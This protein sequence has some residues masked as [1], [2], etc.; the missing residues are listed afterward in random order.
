M[1]VADVTGGISEKMRAMLDMCS[2]GRDCI[3]VN[4]T[5]G[6]RLYSLLTGKGAVSTRAVK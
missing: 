6:G 3:L 5:V 2:E 1:S 4:G